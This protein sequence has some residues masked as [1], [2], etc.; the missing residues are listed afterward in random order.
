MVKVPE[1]PE[2]PGWRDYFQ[3]VTT[4]LMV[5]LGFYILWQTIFVRWAIPSLIFGIALLL[6][7]LFRVRMIW[8]YF[9]QRGRRSGI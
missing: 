2:R 1:V 3:I 7:S 5:V 4:G 9:Q 6:Y 8:T